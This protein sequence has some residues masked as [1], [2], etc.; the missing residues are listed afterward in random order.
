MKKNTENLY[1]FYTTWRNEIEQITQDEVDRVHE[2]IEN[3]E[4]F[5]IESIP[6]YDCGEADVLED[7][8][9]C[10]E[11][12]IFYKNTEI[13]PDLEKEM[14]NFEKDNY[15]NCDK[16]EIITFKEMEELEDRYNAEHTG[17]NDKHEEYYRIGKMCQEQ[18]I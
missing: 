17:W 18:C 6:N 7:F 16:D 8:R 15:D 3:G 11:M 2:L 4:E 5:E 14:E 1:K 9:S 13:F 10:L 12:E